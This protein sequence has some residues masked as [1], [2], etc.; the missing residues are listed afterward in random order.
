MTVLEPVSRPT[1]KSRVDSS[2]LGANGLT[3]NERLIKDCAVD[4]ALEEPTYIHSSILSSQRLNDALFDLSF[5]RIKAPIQ[6][7]SIQN[8]SPTRSR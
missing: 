6:R 8:K 3:V 5:L 7:I 1:Q 2:V 4:N